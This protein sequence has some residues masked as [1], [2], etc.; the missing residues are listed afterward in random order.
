M[1]VI[2]RYLKFLLY[3]VICLNYMSCAVYMTACPPSLL[4][5]SK[6]KVMLQSAIGHHCIPDS[7]LSPIL[8]ASGT[9]GD[10]YTSSVYFAAITFMTVGFGDF[11]AMNYHEVQIHIIVS[12][13]QINCVFTVNV[14][15]QHSTFDLQ[16]LTLQ[17]TDFAYHRHESAYIRQLRYR[18]NVVES[19]C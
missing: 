1:S 18:C 2:V 13:R 4:I 15:V 7:W 14:H 17:I 16:H 11:S 3:M 8:R 10:L 9:I 5:N 6:D 12:H 19:H